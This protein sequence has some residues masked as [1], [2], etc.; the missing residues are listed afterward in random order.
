MILFKYNWYLVNEWGPY[1][2]QYPSIWLR[3]IEGGKYTFALFGPVG[4]W[5]VTGG[6]GFESISQKTGTMPSSLIV[7]IDST[8]QSPT[9]ELKFIGEGFTTQFGDKIER[10]KIFEFEW[11]EKN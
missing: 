4:N 11:S 2:F 7:G 3:S 6:E 9:I 1:N 10:G 8:A 5:K